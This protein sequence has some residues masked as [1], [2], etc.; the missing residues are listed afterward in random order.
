[1]ARAFGA[2]GQRIDRSVEYLFGTL[3]SGINLRGL[4]QLGWALEPFAGTPVP[5]P[6]E[7]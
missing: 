3:K 6:L 2:G 5:P 4:F 7:N 1:M